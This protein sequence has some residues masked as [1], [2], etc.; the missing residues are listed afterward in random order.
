LAKYYFNYYRKKFGL[1]SL[2]VAPEF[3]RALLNHSWPG[4]I[5]ELK[6]IIERALLISDVDSGIG[7]EHLPEEFFL[8]QHNNEEYVKNIHDKLMSNDDGQINIMKIAEDIAITIVLQKEGGNL[9]R[10]AKKLGMARNTL[11][12][13]IHNNEK[14][15]NAQKLYKKTK[16]LTN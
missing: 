11:Y 1:S 15:E 6:N 16:G 5:R 7:V 9:S 12:Q 13:K 10:T 8:K 2:N 14:L 3:Y 4:N